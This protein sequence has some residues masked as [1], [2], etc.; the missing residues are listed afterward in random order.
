MW[1]FFFVRWFACLPLLHMLTIPMAQFS[2][3]CLYRS[4]L[5]TEV[6]D[7]FFRIVMRTKKWKMPHRNFFMTY[8]YHKCSHQY[9][10][11]S[12]SPFR[13]TRC[14]A[15]APEQF[16]K[17]PIVLWPALAIHTAIFIPDI[18]RSH[19]YNIEI[20]WCEICN[21]DILTQTLTVWHET[22]Q[23]IN[24]QWH[25]LQFAQLVFWFTD[26][27]YTLYH[28]SRYTRKPKPSSGGFYLINLTVVQREWIYNSQIGN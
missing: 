25:E 15:H 13:L 1:M 23:K 19:I 28:I 7:I 18:V 17:C 26:I 3:E 21:R 12:Y 20:F 2:L 5:I 9:S 22:L 6:R 16:L 14:L 4:L 11:F 10:P 8:P 24:I 27:P